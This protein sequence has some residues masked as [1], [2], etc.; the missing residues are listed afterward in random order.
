[1]GLPGR[2]FS[3]RDLL[4]VNSFNAELMGDIIQTE[5]T[6]YKLAPNETA[7]NI[8]GESDPRTGFATVGHRSGF[9][10]AGHSSRF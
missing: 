1:M 5:V 8:Y 6:V 7:L 3:E 9:E 10:G 4:L 2:Y